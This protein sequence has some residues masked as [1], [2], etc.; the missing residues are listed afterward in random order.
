MTEPRTIQSFPK[1]LPPGAAVKFV[2]VD[3]HTGNRSAVWRVSTGK[4]KDDIYLMEV[5]T[6]RSWKVS[7]HTAGGVARIAMTSEEARKNGRGRSVADEWKVE[8]TSRGWSEGVGVIIPCPYLRPATEQIAD[9][10]STVGT[11]PRH[12]S[13]RIRLFFEEAEAE[14]V[15]VD[16]SFVIAI[17]E[18][19]SGGLVWVVATPETLSSDELS[20]LAERCREFERDAS[21][22]PEEWDG[23]FIGVLVEGEGRWLVDLT[24]K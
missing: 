3:P 8:P 9:G 16:N 10:V 2:A 21:E 15:W 20:F 1:P 19:P 7:H 5:I 17:L 24:T 22:F 23:R 11:S 14:P 13:V 18:R 4:Y 12:S 6:G